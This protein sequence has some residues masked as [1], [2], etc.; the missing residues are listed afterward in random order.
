MII[1]QFLS[2]LVTFP[3]ILLL[4]NILGY[5]YAHYGRLA[6]LARNP[7]FVARQEPERF[8][9]LYLDYLSNFLRGDWGVQPGTNALSLRE[10]MTNSA[11][12]SGG[13]ILIAFLISTMLGCAIGLNAVRTSPLRVSG[14]VIPV[15]TISLAMPGFYIGALLITASVFYLLFAPLDKKSLP[16]PLSGFGWDVHLVLPVIVLTVRPM[17][18]TAQTTATLLANE[19]RAMYV[20]AARSLGFSWKR[21]R[22]HVALRNILSTMVVTIAGSLRMMVG[23]LILVEWLF[24]WPGLGRLFATT[25]Q[26]PNIATIASTVLP[27]SFLHPPLMALIVT[28]FAALFLF[29]DLISVI[30]TL[31]VDPRLR[32]NEA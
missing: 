4:V 15:S 2:R 5:A 31:L 32:R 25:I 1:K 21:V 22:W 8:F 23:E 18:Q 17:M 11:L 27:S 29:I 30:L 7:L 20:T 14:W 10:L 3:L 19:M 13:L 26:P 12:A 28:A 9:P 16:F 6:Q 24:G